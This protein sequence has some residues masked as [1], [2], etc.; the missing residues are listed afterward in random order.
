MRHGIPVLSLLLAVVSLVTISTVYSSIRTTRS[1]WHV[2][3]T[4]KF[5]SG[6][7]PVSIQP[8]RFSL[9]SHLLQVC[10]SQAMSKSLLIMATP[11]IE[12]SNGDQTERGSHRQF[13]L[14]QNVQDS[15]SM[16]KTICTVLKNSLT[17][18]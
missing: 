13:E 3:T 11:T 16:S 10:S 6:A 1:S 14:T 4:V 9:I 17:K 15:L 7:M 8:Q 12:S 18:Y 2:E 5:S